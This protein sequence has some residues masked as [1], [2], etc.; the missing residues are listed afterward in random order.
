ME[1]ELTK[2]VIGAAMA[3][4][5]ELGCGFLESV[6]QNSL[7][8]ELVSLG[9]KVELEKSIQVTY[10]GQIVGNFNADLFIEDELIV[11]LKAVEQLARIHEVQT[12]NYLTATNHDIGLLIN[13]G[14]PSLQFKRKY[15]TKK[16]S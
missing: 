4:H 1:D 14:A 10:Q 9:L 15:R 7:A 8:V 3:V 5:R 13:F 16:S 11:E 6:Y 2:T 12:V